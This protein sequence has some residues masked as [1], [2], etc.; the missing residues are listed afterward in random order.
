MRCAYKVF[1][2]RAK[3][4]DAWKTIWFV[5]MGLNFVAYWLEGVIWN[6]K[7]ASFTISH[8]PS[9][10]LK[11]QNGNYKRFILKP[12]A[13][14]LEATSPLTART[15]AVPMLLQVRPSTRLG[16]ITAQTEEENLWLEPWGQGWAMMSS[17]CVP[18]INWQCWDKVGFL[19]NVGSIK[20]CLLFQ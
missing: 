1:S 6:L 20:I 5:P 10:L 2:T 19:A 14:I 12:F 15:N 7:S 13:N 9:D 8:I 16:L 11:G 18:S 4:R 17:V 3:V